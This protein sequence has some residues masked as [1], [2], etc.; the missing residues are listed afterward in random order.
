MLVWVVVFSDEEGCF[1]HT[2]SERLDF[3]S[4][5][6]VH[7]EVVVDFFQGPVQFPTYG[8]P[9]GRFEVVV[10]EKEEEG[11]GAEQG[12]VLPVELRIAQF[13]RLVRWWLGLGEAGN[14]RR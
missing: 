2:D 5:C 11:R 8:H 9:F 4:G 7:G 1:E 13:G 6:E 3:Y 12:G 14:R 10:L